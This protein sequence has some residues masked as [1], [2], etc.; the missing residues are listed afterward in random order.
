MNIKELDAELKRI[1]RVFFDD[2]EIVREALAEIRRQVDDEL[3]KAEP[4]EIPF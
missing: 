2:V 1:E 4:E 3:L